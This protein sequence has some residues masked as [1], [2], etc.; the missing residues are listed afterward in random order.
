MITNP[1]KARILVDPMRR[2]ITRLLAHRE[3][4]EKELAENLGLSDPA[5][6]HHLGILRKSG[7]IRI[8]KRKIEKH[9]IIQKFYRANALVYLVD[10]RDMPLE[11]ERYFMP[12]SLERV[13]GIVAAI[14]AINDK[15]ERISTSELESFAKIMTTAI[16][17][18]APK[19]SKRSD[20]DSEELMSMIYQE[21]FSRLLRRPHLLPDKLQR[22]FL[23]TQVRSASRKRNRGSRS[24][25]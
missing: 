24:V 14:T 23:N 16:L 17:R 4:T 19:H 2:E 13:R 21:A 5:V 6:G 22:L 25:T 20:L 18:A 10:P 7:M 15:P 9:G 8:A 1:R 11:I 3:M 12:R